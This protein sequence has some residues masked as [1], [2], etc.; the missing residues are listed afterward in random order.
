MATDNSA[1]YVLLT[2]LADEFAARY[3]AGERPP[4]QEYFDRHPELADDISELFPAMVEIEQ[5]REHH[6]EAGAPPPPPPASRQLGDFRFVRE[7]RQGRHGHHL[8]GRAGLAGASFKVRYAASDVMKSSPQRGRHHRARGVSPEE[9]AAVT[10]P[11]ARRHH[12]ISEPPTGAT[13]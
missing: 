13:S 12:S 7:S 8:R 11:P 5:V 3:R 10:Q 4:L 6:Q 2:R 9:G 1:N